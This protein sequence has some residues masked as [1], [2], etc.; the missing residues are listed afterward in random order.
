MLTNTLAGDATPS[1]ALKGELETL[2][3]GLK[4]KLYWNSLEAG[5]IEPP[6]E[7]TQ[8]LVLHA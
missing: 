2:T 6:S 8:P 3:V 5:G 4:F 1:R 7:R